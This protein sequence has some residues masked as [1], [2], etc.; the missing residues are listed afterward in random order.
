M[1]DGTTDLMM[2]LIST[3]NREIM[4]GGGPGHAMT[5]VITASVK[6]FTP[7]IAAATD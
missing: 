5:R 1:N 4:G 7:S 6:P 2:D 3:Q